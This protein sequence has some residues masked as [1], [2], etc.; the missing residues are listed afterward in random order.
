[1]TRPFDHGELNVP[2]RKRGDIDRQLD[3]YHA[4]RRREIEAQAK[5]WRAAR[6]AMVREAIELVEQVPADRLAALG[7]PHGWSVSRTRKELRSRAQM[8]PEATARA[9]RREVAA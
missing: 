8:W 1:M 5:A 9:L 2:L 3:R 6:K 4:E 7:K